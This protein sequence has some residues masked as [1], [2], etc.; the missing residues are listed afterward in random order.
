MARK[1]NS[2]TETTA[3][4]ATPATAL[5]GRSL[6]SNCVRLLSV[7]DTQKSP[8]KKQKKEKKAEPMGKKVAEG[9]IA[10]GARSGAGAGADPKDKGKKAAEPEG[11]A[12]DVADESEEDEDDP[13]RT[14]IVVEHWYFTLSFFLPFCP[15]LA[16]VQ[17]HDNE[18]KLLLDFILKYC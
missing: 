15:F 14:V 13:N 16:F 3:V 17:M 2:N 7:E 12:S 8:A 6:C 10:S 11:G 5:G 1:P 4:G 9:E 18:E